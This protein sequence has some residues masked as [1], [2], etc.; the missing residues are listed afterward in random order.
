MMVDHHTGSL[1]IPQALAVGAEGQE[2]AHVLMIIRQRHLGS[3]R[4]QDL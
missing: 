3:R 1:L 2:G 4:S